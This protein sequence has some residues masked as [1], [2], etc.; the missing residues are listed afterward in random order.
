MGLAAYGVL[1][2][3]KAWGAGLPALVCVVMGV[4]TAS[5]GGIVRDVLAGEPSILLRREI[6]VTAAAL[7]A[8]A[9]TVLVALG[10][11]PLWAGVAGAGAGFALRAGAL[12]RGWALPNF[13]HR[14]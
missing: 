9:F 11:P 1:V 4:L 7:A 13:P 14:A 2:A 8:T 12:A 6:Y 5:F 10:V 3:A